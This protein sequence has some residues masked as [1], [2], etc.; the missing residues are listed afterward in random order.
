MRLR[1]VQA[2]ALYEI[3]TTGGLVGPIKVGGGKTLISLLAPVMLGS[4]TPLLIM[5]ARLIDKTRRELMQLCLHWRINP[6]VEMISYS[7]LG[8][9]KAAEYLEKLRPDCIVC[10]EAHKIRNRKASVTRRVVRYCEEY[11]PRLIV[12]SGTLVRKRLLDWA[13]LSSLALGD[14][15]PAPRKWNTI[16]RWGNAVDID[17]TIK[18]GVLSRWCGPGESVREGY[19]R[20]VAETEGVV[21]SPPEDLGVALTIARWQCDTPAIVRSAIDLLKARWELPDGLPITDPLHYYR[22]A[23]QLSLGVYYRY[24]YPP[25]VQWLEA[26]RTWGAYVRHACRYLKVDGRPLDSEF[27]VANACANG[28]LDSAQAYENWRAIRDTFKPEIEHVWIDHSVV[29]AIIAEARTAPTI[30]WVEHR[31]V[32]WMLHERGLR[33]YGQ[34]GRSK[35]GRDILDADPN[36]S[37]AASLRSAGTGLN[38]QAWA[39]L[40]YSSPIPDAQVWQQS[41]GRVHRPGQE[42]DEC[43]ALVAMLSDAHEDAWAKALQHAAFLRESTGDEPK[44]LQAT[45]VDL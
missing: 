32:G 15:S 13:H 41:L 14:R 21:A 36:D 9:A 16:A 10:D 35:D 42:A 11:N 17:A 28:Y 23:R 29:D 39:R 4:H 34:Q 18:P 20:R 33:Y 22:A 37:F 27:M 7:W 1:P 30:V 38:L 3:A 31:A 43:E 19:Q 5:P 12:L 2:I 6:R 25:P 44:L 26:R 45:L 24:K 40:L 8:R